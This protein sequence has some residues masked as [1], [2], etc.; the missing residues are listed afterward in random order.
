MVADDLLGPNELFVR[1]DDFPECRSDDPQ[2]DAASNQRV[3]ERIAGDG[4]QEAGEHRGE[5]DIN[6][7]NVVDVGQSDRRVVATRRPKQPGAPQF[8]AAAPRPTTI[9]T[10]P[11]TGAGSRSR[12]TDCQS[13]TPLTRMRPTELKIFADRRRLRETPWDRMKAR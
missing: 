11:M 8:A 1:F 12:S 5:R 13:S 10:D 2:R 4:D 9:A 3:E 6:V 7:A